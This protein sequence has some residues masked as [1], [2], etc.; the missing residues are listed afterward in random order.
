MAKEK[1][2]EVTP[3]AYVRLRVRM[4]K[5]MIETD[6][7]VE[8]PVPSGKPGTGPEKPVGSDVLKENSGKSKKS[9]SKEKDK[10]ET[11]LEESMMDLPEMRVNKPIREA[12][13]CGQL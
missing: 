1:A 5:K 7:L 3:E 8:W 9:K 2:V 11:L 4:A 12:R 13:E 6:T 10:T